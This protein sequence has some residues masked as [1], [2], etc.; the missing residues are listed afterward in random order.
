MVGT[1]IL[2]GQAIHSIVGSGSVVLDL[3]LALVSI[4][5]WRCQVA[6]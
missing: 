1:G 6:V 2:I 3:M 4:V 5:E